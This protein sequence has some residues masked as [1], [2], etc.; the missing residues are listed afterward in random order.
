MIVTK[1]FSADG[2]KLL[3]AI[4][5]LEK[6]S[7][8]V[9]WF[10]KSHYDDGTQVATVAAQNEFGNPNKNIPARPFMR[11][12]LIKDKKK[13]EKLTTDGAK[14]ILKGELTIDN[15]L[16]FLGQQ[17]TKDIKDTISKIY[18]PA[19]AERTILARIER[20]SKLSRIKGPIKSA[21]LGSVTKPLI[22]TG[23]MFNTITH[24]LRDE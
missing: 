13:W 10:E 22:D 24:E 3:N 7:V 23:V 16:N 21:T 18:H 14:K 8:A 9:G 6:K 1:I 19:L 4:Q 11:P 12:T 5:R 17:V 2:V 15:V 20:S